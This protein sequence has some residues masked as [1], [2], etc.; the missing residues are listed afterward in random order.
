PQIPLVKGQYQQPHAH[1]QG[2]QADQ[3]NKEI[4]RR[5]LDGWRAGSGSHGTNNLIC[6]CFDSWLHRLVKRQGL[7]LLEA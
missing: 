4:R 5:G 6:Y 3:K 2:D 7:L 1:S